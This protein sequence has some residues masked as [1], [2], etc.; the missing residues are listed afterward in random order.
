VLDRR[1]FR[2]SRLCLM[3]LTG[4]LLAASASSASAVVAY[5]CYFGPGC[6]LTALGPSGASY[7][8]GAYWS[9][10]F[11]SQGTSGGW[12]KGGEIKVN[13]TPYGPWFGGGGPNDIVFDKTFASVHQVKR[14]FRTWNGSSL[15]REMRGFYICWTSIGSQNCILSAG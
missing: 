10:G 2:R 12:T 8:T 15:T 13:G 9:I 11:R 14:Q 7:W 5:K 4:G 1:A 6:A 3:L